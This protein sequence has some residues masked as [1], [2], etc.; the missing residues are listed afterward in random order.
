MQMRRNWTGWIVTLV[1]VLGVARA[2]AQILKYVPDGAFLVVKLNKPEA[3]NQKL[4]RVFQRLGVANLDPAFADPLAFVRNKLNLQQGVNLSGE[5]AIALFQPGPNERE[6]R[7]LILMPVSDYAKFLG[8]FAAGQKEGQIDS[9]TFAGNEAE[10]LFAVQWDQWAAVSPWKEL[11]ATRP[12]GLAV[13]PAVQ[14]QMD[15]KDVCAYLSIASVRGQVLPGIQQ[16]KAFFQTPQAMPDPNIQPEITPF[17]RAMFL[18]VLDIIEG[19]FVQTRAVAYGLSIQ[20]EGLVTTFIGEFE[21]NSDAATMMA[22]IKNTSEDFLAG[23]PAEKYLVYG[24]GLEGVNVPWEPIRKMFYGAMRKVQMP[25]EEMKN[26][27]EALA[28]TQQMTEL[29]QRFSFGLTQPDVQAGKGVF[30]GYLLRFG[31]ARALLVKNRE[32]A[33]KSEPIMKL[34]QP[35]GV[36]MRLSLKP[37]AK[38]IGGVLMDQFSMTVSSHANPQNP[39]EMQ[40]SKMIEIIYGNSMDGFVGP[41]GDTMLFASFCVDEGRVAK[42]LAT[43]RSGASAL[44]EQEALKESARYLPRERVAVAYVA[45][46]NIVQTVFDTLAKNGIG[47]PVRLPPDLPPIAASLSVD[48]K[49]L[50]ADS[51]VPLTLVENMVSFF[52]Q[53]QIRQAGQRGGQ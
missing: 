14:K 50:R 46:D 2:Q 53:M 4:A 9:F 36:D 23:L 16:I 12:A 37:E 32:V 28:L 42:A 35:P 21:P 22:G 29:T 44:G 25:V 5:V 45:V 30:Q 49:D 38:T 40:A 3:V 17:Q 33:R 20:E 15:E 19:M 31:D 48:G 1:L 13:D 47:A 18:G 6:P 34:S 10:P 41:V 27:E 51:Y 24:G 52:I 8:N 26:V 11:V 39:A 43:A 7:M